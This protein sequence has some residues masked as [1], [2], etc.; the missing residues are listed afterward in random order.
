MKKRK[1]GTSVIE[2]APLAFGGNV[3]GWTA[4]EPTSFQV[5]D[6]FVAAGFNFIDTADVYSK[7]AQGHQG[8]ESESILGRWLKKSGKRHQ[9]VVATKV[10][11]EMGPDKKGLSKSY[12]LRAVEDSLRRLQI[13]CIDLYQAHVDDP[14][15]PLEEPLDAFGHLI[16]Q[17]KVRAIG[18]S[19]YSGNRLT[20]ALEISRMNGLPRYECL[21]PHYNLCER[22]DYET[23]LEPVCLTH[24]LGVISYF[25]LAKG[26]LTGKYRNE[27]DLTK[28][29]RG[30]GVKAYLNE[31]GFRILA[32]LDQI[33][34]DKGSTPAR[35]A[36]AW[37]IARPNITAPI[38]SATSLGQLTD[39]IEAT[40]LELDRPA[41]E[42][43]NQASARA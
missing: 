33:A 11:M 17:G 14:A 1:L 28:S 4:D 12:I 19:N 25:S 7:W 37:L 18:A 31:R 6:A 36:L 8:G 3:F 10:G 35:V 34:K 38:A 9:V 15:T 24:G 39:L 23:K 13:D 26:F 20:Q 42:A 40:K 41:I 32:A 2:I 22:A 5:L 43:L 27:A 21:Q 30:Q 16:K 29:V